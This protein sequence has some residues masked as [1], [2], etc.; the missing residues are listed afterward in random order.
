MVVVI[1][2]FANALMRNMSIGREKQLN[3]NRL[4]CESEA[5]ERVIHL[6]L[7]KT[8]AQ[9]YSDAFNSRAR[10]KVPLISW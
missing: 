10:R 1:A 2:V 5:L 6:I 9:M 3:F 8:L 4:T 7:V